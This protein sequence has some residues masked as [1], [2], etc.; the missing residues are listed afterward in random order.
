MTI[1]QAEA[2]KRLLARLPV[3]AH[4]VFP[5]AHKGG[6]QRTRIQAAALRIKIRE[7]RKRM[8]AMEIAKTLKLSRTMVYGYTRNR[9]T[10]LT[11]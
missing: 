4:V 9:D 2:H 1:E 3:R 5:K 7:M 11:K 8:S 6:R 10:Q